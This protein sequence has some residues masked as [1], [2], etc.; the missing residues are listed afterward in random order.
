[1]DLI[2][3][4]ALVKEGYSFHFTPKASYLTTPDMKVV[5]LIEKK[6]LYLMKWQRTV[7]PVAEQQRMS[8]MSAEELAAP[9]LTHE[10]EVEVFSEE[11]DEDG[12]DD[13]PISFTDEPEVNDDIDMSEDCCF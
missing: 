7:D 9:V 8:R 5:T 10:E 11:D 13:S 3:V 2:S 12:E 4:S 6:G 1:M